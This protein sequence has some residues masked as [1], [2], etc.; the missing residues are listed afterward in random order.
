MPVF[1][2]AE[3]SKLAMTCP[4]NWPVRHGSFRGI[5][6]FKNKERD[7]WLVREILSSIFFYWLVSHTTCTIVTVFAY[8]VVSSIPL[9]LPHD[10]GSEL[11]SHTTWIVT[12]LFYQSLII[13]FLF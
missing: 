9:V 10:L 1:Y 4:E 3:T 2:L 13:I 5:A 11:V 7:R 8:V 6:I 12:I